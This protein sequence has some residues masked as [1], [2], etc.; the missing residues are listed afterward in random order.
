[1]VCIIN[2]FVGK[3]VTEHSLYQRN[4]EMPFMSI[5]VIKGNITRN[6]LFGTNDPRHQL[7]CPLHSKG[8]RGEGVSEKNVEMLSFLKVNY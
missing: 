1:M 7:S 8:R 3:P 4:M 2:S 6:N 5:S